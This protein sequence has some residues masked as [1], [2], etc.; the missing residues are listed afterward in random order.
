MYF[1]KTYIY[2]VA[3]T[4]L[5]FGFYNF[6][7]A[8]DPSDIK[9][10]ADKV[11]FDYNDNVSNFKGNVNIAYEELSLKADEAK[12]FITDKRASAKGQVMILHQ[13]KVYFCDEL[14]YDFE[15]KTGLMINGATYDGMWILKGSNI[16]QISKNEVHVYDAKMILC[17]N[18]SPHYYMT[19]SD[20][21]LYPGEK[22]EAKNMVFWLGPL[23][24]FYMPYYTLSLNDESAFGI[25]FRQND[26]FG[27]QTLT[28]YKFQPS[29]FMKSKLYLNWYE[30]RGVGFGV[31]NKI[32]S[33]NGNGK[34]SGFYIK[35][36][37]FEPTRSRETEGELERYRVSYDQYNKVK[38]NITST[39]NFNY[40]S[41]LD[42]FDDYFSKE[43]DTRIQPDNRY[44][45][46]YG[47]EDY[48]LS[49][50]LRYN[51]NDFDNSLLRL[52]QFDFN[53]YQHQIGASDFYFTSINQVAYLQHD[54]ADSSLLE[55]KSARSYTGNTI[56][57]SK[58]FFGWLTIN[59]KFKFEALWYSKSLIESYLTETS[60]DENGNEII[61]TETVYDEGSSIVRTALDFSVAFSTNLYK[62]FSFD[63]SILGYSKFRNI[64]TPSIIYSYNPDP[65]K[66]NDDIIQFDELDNRKESSSYLVLSWISRWQAKNDEKTDTIIY[67]QYSFSYDLKADDDPLGNFIYSSDI[68]LAN[69][70]FV[71]FRF[72]YDLE[73]SVTN[74]FRTDLSY[75]FSDILGI[76]LAYWDRYN[77]DNIITPEI[78]L[79]FGN[80]LFLRGYVYYNEESSKIERSEV[81]LIK[82]LHCWDIALQYF[83]KEYRD[84]KTI[85]ISFSPRGTNARGISTS[86]I[87][88]M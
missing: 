50:V 31:T 56:D 84:E 66:D 58:K 22:I 8:I 2:K 36:K 67:N 53:W 15:K 21:I 47:T 20:V 72:S 59:P 70:F 16:K 19:A 4:V 55:Y 60:L 71:D 64:I 38:N 63:N 1:K 87:D 73:E 49:M 41:D 68:R 7:F 81:S 75:R 29:D 65:S 17:Q 79:N 76:S 82:G 40:Y 3:V 13:N 12:V 57:Y 78:S 14:N 77:Q 52:P 61:Q 83:E 69:N 27:F 35:D 42:L 80:E 6:L 24:I 26:I 48:S 43:F 32:F 46:N 44:R 10:N 85:Y 23:P 11:D 5:F 30:K 37:E 39:L 62:V 9:M 45:L 51:P 25:R 34:L 54:Y 28:Y 33:D 88:F 86:G 18:T 74:Y